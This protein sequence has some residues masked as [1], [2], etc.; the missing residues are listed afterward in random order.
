[1]SNVVKLHNTTAVD[2]KTSKEILISNIRDEANELRGMAKQ[3][4]DDTLTIPT[5]AFKE[6][7]DNMEPFEKGI[8]L[9]LEE[10][11]KAEALPDTEVVVEFLE[12]VQKEIREYRGT[13]FTFY[14]LTKGGA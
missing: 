5:D 4:L 6:L 11:E 14:E 12:N 7:C 2:L 9:I 8:D 13:L 3:F 10:A 1:M